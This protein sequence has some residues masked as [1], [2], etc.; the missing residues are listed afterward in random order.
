M[1]RPPSPAAAGRPLTVTRAGSV[2]ST[3]VGADVPVEVVGNESEA[4]TALVALGRPNPLLRR[5]GS[6][7]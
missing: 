4:A 1:R 7:R 5:H 3:G 2:P 6:S